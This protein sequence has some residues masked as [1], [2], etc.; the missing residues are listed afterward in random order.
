MA[1]LQSRAAAGELVTGLDLQW[2]SRARDMHANL[3]T[4]DQAAQPPVRAAAPVRAQGPGQFQRAASLT[5]ISP[6]RLPRSYRRP[7]MDLFH[8]TLTIDCPHCRVRLMR[9]SQTAHMDF[10]I[11]P[12]SPGGGIV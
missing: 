6:D 5:G 12:C 4:V 9:V 7:V 1:Y 2:M 8:M 3:N 11:C 10:A